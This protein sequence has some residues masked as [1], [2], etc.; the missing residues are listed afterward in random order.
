MFFSGLLFG[1]GVTVLID[2]L[3]DQHK[4]QALL[5]EELRVIH[6]VLTNNTNEESEVNS[7]LSE[8]P[9][10]LYDDETDLSYE[11]VRKIYDS[12]YGE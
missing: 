6:S 5:E 12:Y 2:Y 9:H 1:A 11:N 8:L 10:E 7:M 3:I 4:K